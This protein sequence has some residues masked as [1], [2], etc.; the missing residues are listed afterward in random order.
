MIVDTSALIACVAEEEDSESVYRALVRGEGLL[1]APALVEYRRVASRAKHIDDQ[2][3]ETFVLDLLDGP[4]QLLDFRAEH[5]RV[6][7]AANKLYGSGVARGGKLNLL[8]LM[9]YACAKVERRAILCTGRDFLDTDVP[10]H[11]AS[12]L[13]A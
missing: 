5:A 9:I 4:L 10:I 12:R 7:A 2:R 8:D 11:P 1:P 3:A 6:A 13:S